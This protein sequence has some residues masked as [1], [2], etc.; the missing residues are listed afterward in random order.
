M[1]APPR[2]DPTVIELTICHEPTMSERV[3]SERRCGREWTAEEVAREQ[4]AAG[5]RV[6]RARA[7]GAEANVKEAAAL[8]RFANRVAAAAEIARSDEAPLKRSIPSRCC[9]FFICRASCTSLPQAR[10]RAG[11]TC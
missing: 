7:R 3:D 1:P 5:A 9:G 10:A 4:A 8:A 11:A 6:A 2:G